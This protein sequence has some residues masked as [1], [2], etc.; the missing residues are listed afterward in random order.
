MLSQGRGGEQ[1]DGRIDGHGGGEHILAAD[2]LGAVGLP[3]G[4]GDG[5]AVGDGA[6]RAAS[7]RRRRERIRARPPGVRARQRLR[8][9]EDGRKRGEA[10]P[11]GL[12]FSPALPPRGRR[13][14][15]VPVEIIEQAAIARA[16]TTPGA[17]ADAGRLG[18]GPVA[19]GLGGRCP[20]GSG[21]GGGGR[22]P[23][24]S[25][26]AVAHHVP[27][28]VAEAPAR[29][30]G[31]REVLGPR[32]PTAA[33]VTATTSGARSRKARRTCRVEL[34]LAGRIQL[35]QE[36]RGWGIPAPG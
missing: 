20:P 3:G 30:Q 21:G 25:A 35:V 34:E 24:P 6:A 4:A 15:P 36:R 19:G 22:A 31:G 33:G 26:F 5:A 29:S 7:P 2:P 9:G 10:R 17:A 28:Q 12:H 13:G 27:R 16:R 23:R 11:L 1:K 14:Q 32:G 8:W 18:P